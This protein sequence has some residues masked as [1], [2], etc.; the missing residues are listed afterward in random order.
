MR[1]ALPLAPLCALLW[2]RLACMRR[3]WLSALVAIVLIVEPL[4]ASL[5][6]RRLLSGED[7]R[8]Q[9]ERWL[10]DHAANGAWVVNLPAQVGGNIEAL[11]PESVFAREQRFAH[12]FSGG[13]LL[14]AYAGLAEREDL[15]PLYAFLQ[16]NALGPAPGA[17][18]SDST[19]TAYILWYRHPACPQVKESKARALLAR[20]AWVEEFSPGDIERALYEPVDWYFAPIGD[21][22]AVERTGP[23][24]KLGRVKVGERGG[25]GD[26]RAFFKILHGIL[27]GKVLTAKGAWE[28][29]RIFYAEVA[30]TPLALPKVLNAAYLYDYLYSYGLCYSKIGMVP[31][32]ITLWEQALA[33]K[34]EEAELHNN[35]GVAYARLGRSEQAANH[36]ATAT[37]LDARY[38]EAHFNLGNVLY[39][40]AD[41]EGALAAWKWA[42]IA[43]PG[44]AR[45]H[46]NLG[47]VHYEQ[48][49]W[50]RAIRSYRRAID[51]QPRD[52]RIYYNLA[53]AFLKTAEPDSA[54]NALLHF[55][56]IDAN[57]AEVHFR[58]GVLY[59]QRGNDPAARSWFAKVLALEPEHPSAVEIRAYMEGL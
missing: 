9:A 11:Y 14:A 29:A 21:F 28:E 40:Q 49:E 45:A 24:I 51:L 37:T 23:R 50:D 25:Q 8:E 3:G 41:R 34:G 35:L 54:I 20:C 13:D 48:G 22:A 30:R 57:D 47:N 1:Y 36:L 2:A 15:P 17:V 7:T 52:S 18:E 26:A 38:A 31:Q 5:Q 46:F 12:S 10:G 33:L 19:G 39:R 32:A 59:R 55:V 6:T 58:L 16:P 27:K 56:E 53:Q 43:D 44:F 4:A 42:V